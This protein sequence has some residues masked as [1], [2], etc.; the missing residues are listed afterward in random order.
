MLIKADMHSHSVASVH[1]YSTVRE[2]AECAS[3]NGLEAFALTDHAPLSPDSPHIWHFENMKCLPRKI[4]GVYVI[5]GIEANIDSDGN[6]DLSEHL[7]RRVE[8]VVASLHNSVVK[9]NP[10]GDFSD[11]YINAVKNYPDID[12]IG[13]CTMNSFPFDYERVLK[14]FKEYGKLVE[15]NESS[16]KNH[17][18]AVKNC[19]RILEI[20][21]KYEIPVTVDTDAH[22]CELI[23]ITPL[24]EKII[25][26]TE[27]PKKLIVNSS[28]EKIFEFISKKR[29]ISFE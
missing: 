9:G 4:H 16:L 3:L 24:A 25:E 26:D 28:A 27:F 23:G 15:I 6:T 12:V 14:I 17:E 10:S 22:Y 19:I 20:C 21:K 13:H 1:A 18:G 11:L 8:W 5:K 29:N 7:A 2:I